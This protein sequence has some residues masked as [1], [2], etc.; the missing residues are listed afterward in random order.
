VFRRIWSYI[1]TLFRLGA[2]RAMNPEVEIEQ[3]INEARRRDQELRNQAAKVIAHRTQI[4]TKIEQAARSL[5]EARETT[6]Q[7]CVPI[8]PRT[9]GTPPIRPAGPRR[10]SHWP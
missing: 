7:C 4:E 9:R 3:A 5:G 2:E 6:K 8:R 1:K 10:P